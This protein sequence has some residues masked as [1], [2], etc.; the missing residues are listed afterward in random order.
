MLQ[1]Y[2]G[3][4]QFALGDLQVP[5]TPSARLTAAI[6]A[7][8]KLGWKLGVEAYTFHKFTFFEAI[9]K[10][11]QLGLP[12]IGGLSFQKVSQE[13]PKNFDPRC[14]ENCKVRLKLE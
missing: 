14:D 10:T 7:Q 4:I 12:Y 6:R 11:S 2:L 8:E 9:E 1:F 5:T 3:A 13:I